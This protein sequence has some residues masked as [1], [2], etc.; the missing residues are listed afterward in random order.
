M[1]TL[2]LQCLCHFHH[3]ILKKKSFL[4]FSFILHIFLL[5]RHSFLCYFYSTA[6]VSNQWKSNSDRTLKTSPISFNL[7]IEGLTYFKTSRSDIQAPSV[8]YVWKKKKN[9]NAKANQLGDTKT[10]NLILKLH[11]S[12]GTNF[13][14]IQWSTNMNIVVKKIFYTNEWSQVII[15]IRITSSCLKLDETYMLHI[16]SASTINGWTDW[17][18]PVDHMVTSAQTL[19]LQNSGLIITISITLH[20]VQLKPQP[21]CLKV[22]NTT[23][24]AIQASTF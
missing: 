6:W 5:L 4:L 19:T 20:Y 1:I 16:C 14:L 17:V 22:A 18:D 9:D 21:S 10:Q 13:L 23:H 11:P 12:S 15:E 24:W 3:Q 8:I 7:Q 2:V